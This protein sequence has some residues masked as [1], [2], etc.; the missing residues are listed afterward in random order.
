MS[1]RV[2]SYLLVNRAL[3]VIRHAQHL[4]MVFL[5]KGSCGMKLIVQPT[6]LP[7]RICFKRRTSRTS[8]IGLGDYSSLQITLAG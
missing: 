7:N 4:F 1:A 2:T 6:G 5:A 8:Q 3:I